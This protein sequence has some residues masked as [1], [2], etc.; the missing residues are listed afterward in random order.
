MSTKCLLKLETVDFLRP[1][2]FNPV[3]E[4]YIPDLGIVN[5]I[6]IEEL[7]LNDAKAIYRFLKKNKNR[8]N[9]VDIDIQL[10]SKIIINPKIIS[11]IKSVFGFDLVYNTSS[12]FNLIHAILKK[13]RIEMYDN[14]LQAIIHDENIEM[15]YFYA[16]ESL[17]ELMY[18]N[19]DHFDSEESDELKDVYNQIENLQGLINLPEIEYEFKQSENY[20]PNVTNIIQSHLL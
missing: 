1:E 18:E 2:Y 19:Y 14:Y 9:E 7:T 4:D 5:I 16:A 8:F 6:S 11:S 13:M 12:K 10:T 17:V 15:K 3:S 20:E